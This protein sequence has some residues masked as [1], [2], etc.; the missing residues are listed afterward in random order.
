LPRMN[1]VGGCCGTDE[2]HVAS[3]ARHLTGR[4]ARAGPP[5]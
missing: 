1:V 2:R 4:A 3:I 5:T